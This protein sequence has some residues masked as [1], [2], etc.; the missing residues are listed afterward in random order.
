MG[1]PVHGI[2]GIIYVAWSIDSTVDAAEA[3]E[4][5]DTWK[6]HVAGL[7]TWSGSLS[8]WEQTDNQ[9]LFQAATAGA[10]V[11]L[12]IYPTADGSDYYSGNAIFAASSAGDS[13]SPV[14][15]NA[16]FTGDGTLTIAGFA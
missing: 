11:A 16:T 13:S 4:F 10:S 8:A 9:L 6:K 15:K 14:S 2:N 7:L 3:P 5:G 12:L 1:A